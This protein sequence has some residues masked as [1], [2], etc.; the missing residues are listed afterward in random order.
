M[1]CVCPICKE[2]VSDGK[3]KVVLRQKG[4]DGVNKASAER[5]DS[6]RVQPGNVVHQ[7]CRQM[8]VN[9]N[10]IAMFLKKKEREPSKDVDEPRNLRSS[11]A[12]F[13]I[14]E[15]CLFCAL[16]AKYDGK[17][18]GYGVIQVRT[19][20]ITDTIK[21]ICIQR[22]D[23]WAK[24]V[25]ARLLSV[26]DLHAANVVFKSGIKIWQIPKNVYRKMPVSHTELIDRVYPHGQLGHGPLVGRIDCL[27]LFAKFFHIFNKPT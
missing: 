4:S 10:Q 27:D 2:D 17:K 18:K 16:P 19:T 24:T 12:P 11:E 3:D 14:K 25:H 1:N 9:K 21:N 26:H 15:Q 23:K 20:A 7:K 22:E 5:K 8:Y 13:N 6:L